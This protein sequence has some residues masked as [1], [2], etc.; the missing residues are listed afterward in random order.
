MSNYLY[1]KSI[2]Y[3]CVVYCFIT[4]CYSWKL[5]VNITKVLQFD[6]LVSVSG[7]VLPCFKH[8]I[9][10]ICCIVSIDPWYSSNVRISENSSQVTPMRKHITY[11]YNLSSICTSPPAS[12]V[13]HFKA[14]NTRRRIQDN[15]ILTKKWYGYYIK[16]IRNIT[17]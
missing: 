5:S 9:R 17:C 4:Q 16:L 15:W 10:D 11:V 7:F 3:S 1:V 2:L 13:G 14:R 8:A 12:V 6:Y